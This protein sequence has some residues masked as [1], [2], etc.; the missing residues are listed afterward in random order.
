MIRYCCNCLIYAFPQSPELKSCLLSKRC[1]TQRSLPASEV[2]FV[3]SDNGSFLLTFNYK[4][5]T[6]AE[7]EMSLVTSVTVSAWLY[8]L[9]FTVDCGRMFCDRISKLLC[10]SVC[11]RISLEAMK[12][13]LSFW[14][15]LESIIICI[16]DTD[17]AESPDQHVRAALSLSDVCRWLRRSSLCIAH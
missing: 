8:E 6:D 3:T 12:T 14:S 7:T 2:V 5:C 11:G 9:V 1:Y 17:W 10:V 4:W 13:R 16:M 15:N